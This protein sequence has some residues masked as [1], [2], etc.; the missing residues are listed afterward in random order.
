[1][2]KLMNGLTQEQI[3]DLEDMIQRRMDHTGESRVESAEHL[4]NY[5]LR[6]LKLK[7]EEETHMSSDR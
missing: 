6:R 4:R 2:K 1:M 3:N 7:L 5:F